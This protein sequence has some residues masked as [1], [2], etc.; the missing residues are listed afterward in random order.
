[1]YRLP[2][3]QEQKAARSLQA[4]P[5]FQKIMETFVEERDV[6]MKSLLAASTDKVGQLQGRT[7]AFIEIID[8]LQHNY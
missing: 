8:A 5:A 7:Q 2:K 1:M 3:E 4:N 6:S